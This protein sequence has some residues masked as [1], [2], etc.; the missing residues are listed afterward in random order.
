M[1]KIKLFL[2]PILLALFCNYSFAQSTLELKIEK[3]TIVNTGQII[4]A[5]GTLTIPFVN[6]SGNL[7]VQFQI[8]T[9]KPSGLITNG[10]FKLYTKKTPT[11]TPSDIGSSQNVDNSA[12]SGSGS[13]YYYTTQIFDVTLNASNFNQTGGTFYSVFQTS[14]TTY[15][16]NTFPVEILYYPITNN[17]ITA[18][19]LV[20]EGQTPALLNGSQP[21]GGT[22]SYTYQW[23]QSIDNTNWSSINGATTKNY[24]PSVLTATTYYRRLSNSQYVSQN[25]SNTLTLTYQPIANQ[26]Y[27]TSQS[28]CLNGTPVLIT[29]NTSTIGTVTNQWQILNG[30]NFENIAGAT[31][32]DYQPPVISNPQIKQYRRIVSIQGVNKISNVVTVKYEE[33]GHNSVIPIGP[34]GVPITTDIFGSSPSCGTGSFTFQWQKEISGVWTNIV[35]QTQEDFHLPPSGSKCRRIVYSGPYVSYSNVV[36]TLGSPQKL[37]TT[38]IEGNKNTD[39]SVEIFPNPCANY[40]TFN[41]INTEIK[42]IQIFNLLGELS[43]ETVPTS[44]TIQLPENLISGTYI[45]LLKLSNEEIRNQKITINR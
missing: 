15:A 36:L 23:Q 27:P 16:S 11:S 17:S 26:L 1:K 29:G 30:A 10:T 35:G 7:R 43:Y 6:G 37:I 18:N 2:L 19:Q 24:Q 22:N 42:A 33:I 3:V 8:S 39:V 44:S 32:N 20:Y 28:V 38:D 34:Y 41:T 12:W 25:I 5:G 40:M 13:T 9:A 21:T 31:G 4:N 45:V 14:F